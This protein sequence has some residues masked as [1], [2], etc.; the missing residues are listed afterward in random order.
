MENEEL[1]VE[2]IKTILDKQNKYFDSQVTKNIDFRI[3]QLKKLKEGVKKY[4]DKINQ[5]L[6]SDLGK[7]K[8]EAYMTEVGLVYNTITHMIKNL[9]KWAKPERRKTPFYLM[10]SRSFIIN[11]PYGAVLVISPYNY[12]VELLLEPLVGAI[13]AGNTVVLKPSEI[14]PNVSKVMKEMIDEIFE[15]EYVACVEG[16]IETNTALLNNK[17]DYIFFT[18]SPAV[19]RIVMEAAAKNLTPVTLELGGKS[20]VIVD[21]SANIKEA[22]KRIIWGKTLNAGQTCVAPDYL[23]VK[24][25]VKD[26]LINEMKNAIHEFFGKNIEESNSFGRIINDRHFNRIKGL[27]EKDKEGIVFGGSF[28]EEKRYIEP[29]II[30]VSSLDAATMSEEIFGPVLPVLCY[31]N[32]D[33]AIKIIKKLSK[34]LALYLFTTKKDVE[35][36]VLSEIS[37][38]GV[39]INDTITHLANSNIPFGGVGNSGMGSYHGKD[40]FTTFSHRRSVLKKPSSLGFGGSMMYPEYTEKQ[41]NLVKKV[42][43]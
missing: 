20:P 13:A 39:C 8:N 3:K 7:N 35:Q 19:G 5:A 41:L 23:M 2:D 33:D 16:G 1:T 30:E 4:E 6:Y 27:I 32:L 11:E 28:N 17:F 34:P 9:K 36:K 25:N 15:E 26:Q 14:A 40:T 10:P 31:E 37:S 22:A 24:K 21:D 42:F 43:K 12:P 29:T 38:G 18:G